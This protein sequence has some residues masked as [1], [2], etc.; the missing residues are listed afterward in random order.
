MDVLLPSVCEE[1]VEPPLLGQE[2]EI[3]VELQFES[4]AERLESDLKIRSKRRKQSKV[5][6]SQS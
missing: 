2:V 6:S 5:I 1:D 4:F 3:P